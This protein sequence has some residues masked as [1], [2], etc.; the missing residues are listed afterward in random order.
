MNEHAAQPSPILFFETVNA[1]QRTAALKA[2]LE[3]DVFTALAEGKTTAQAAAARCR[4]AE[5]GM[6]ILLDYLVIIGFLT[7]ADE[8]YALTDDSAFFLDRNNPSYLGGA[9]EFLLAPELTAGFDKLG[10]AVRKGGTTL[11]DEGTMSPENPIWVRFARA[12]MPMMVMPAQA[13]AQLVQVAPS[14]PVKVLDVAAGHG[15]FGITLAQAHS[16]VEV[17]ALDWPSVLQVAQENAQR[18]G[19]GDRHTLLP[20]SAFEVDWGSGYDLVL[21]TNFLHHFDPPACEQLLKKAQAALNEGGR[22]VT[23]EFIPN[24][25]RVTPPPAAT[26]ALMMLGGTAAGDAYIA[27]DY[28][29]MFRHTGFARS[30]FHSL[31]GSPQTVIV[32]QK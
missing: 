27:A 21:L 28:D 9:I 23:L 32:S 24:E 10:E 8:Q 14:R 30:E 20:G 3:L 29:R 25:D 7:K 26:F 17:V 6:R 5:R 13:I 4:T 2:A 12:M 18:F 16:N 22:V 31:P 15:I 11:S 1:Y 19:V